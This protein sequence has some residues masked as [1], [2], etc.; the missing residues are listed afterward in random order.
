MLLG[1]SIGLLLCFG[2][3]ALGKQMIAR[4]EML[5][6][7]FSWAPHFATAYSRIVGRFFFVMGIIGMAFYLILL[8]LLAVQHI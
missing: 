4:P 1:Y 5:A 2:V 3:F 7:I 8:V 6:R